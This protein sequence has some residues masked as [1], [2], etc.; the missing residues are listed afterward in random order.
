MKL[1]LGDGRRRSC[2][3]KNGILVVFVSFVLVG[4]LLVDS[5][6]GRPR[7]FPRNSPPSCDVPRNFNES[8]RWNDEFEINRICNDLHYVVY[9]TPFNYEAHQFDLNADLPNQYDC[10][11]AR[12]VYH[13]CYWCAAENK[14]VV[15]EGGDDVDNVDDGDKIDLVYD[16]DSCSFYNATICENNKDGDTDLQNIPSFVNET[17]ASLIH[18]FE[19]D[20]LFPYST[21]LCRKA[22]L[23]APYCPEY[24]TLVQEWWSLQ[25]NEDD[26]VWEDFLDEDG[27]YN[28]LRANTPGKR[29]AVVWVSR[30]AAILS[31]MG[32]AYILYDALLSNNKRNRKTV[33][34]QLVIGMATFDVASAIAWAFASA[35]IPKFLNN[36]FW[37]V[38]GIVGN[39]ATCRAQGFF[40]QLGLTS[41]YYN[42]SMSTYYLLVIVYSWSDFKLRKI[43]IWLH[44]I[45]IVLGIVLSIWGLRHYDWIEYAC[46]LCPVLDGSPTFKEDYVAILLMVVVPIAISI[47]L[48]VGQLL[49]ILFSVYRKS[50][51]AKR[52]R[53]QSGDTSGRPSKM[54]ILLTKTL[55]Q[56]LFYTLAF[57]IT[58]PM[59]F[60]VYLESVDMN[61]YYIALF[62]AF[63]APLQGFNNF[64]VYVRPRIMN[65][66]DQHRKRRDQLKAKSAKAS[67]KGESSTEHS[68]T[69]TSVAPPSQGQLEGSNID[70]SETNEDECNGDNEGEY[71]DPSVEILDAI[72]KES[73]GLATS[74]TSGQDAL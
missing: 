4:L 18:M 34:H 37:A 8:G 3:A 14:V 61:G 52:W 38:H 1:L 24:C 22:Q 25:M 74:A 71:V 15:V 60:A 70:I 13:L 28:A 40:I 12:Q 55:W 33:Y 44:G 29:K 16:F 9:W 68:S 43:R 64:L 7:C 49:V 21:Q 46:H 41:V 23:S 39:E 50:Q 20:G 63:V 27:R 69:M 72:M 45:P 31:L 58:W 30:S 6:E 26:V 59:V 2:T 54:D 17:C 51:T 36:D 73:T 53:L 66:F 57:S 56:C 19:E 35:P 11:A 10:H 67:R 32:A 48:I 65:F 47:V 42:V 5:V 62:Y